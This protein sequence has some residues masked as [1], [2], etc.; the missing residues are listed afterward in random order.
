MRRNLFENAFRLLARIHDFSKTQQ[1]AAGRCER[2][3]DIPYQKDGSPDHLLD[4]YRPRHAAGPLPVMLYIHG[5]G[6]VMCDKNTHRGIGRIYADN[7][8]VVFNINYRLA[9]QHPYPAAL[10]DAGRA[11]AWVVENAA[12]YG[13]DPNRII[14]AGESAGGNLTLALA[15]AGCFRMHAP[16]ARAIWDV[17]VVPDIIMVMCGYLQ[18]SDPHR[19]FRVCPPINSFSRSLD[20]QIARDV[21]RAYLGRTYRRPDPNRI[22][23]DPLLALE[24]GD[25]PLR[26]FPMVYAMAGASDIIVDDTRRLEQAL[27]KRGIRHV[28]RYFPRQGHAFHLLGIS[29]QADRL[30]QDNLDFLKFFQCRKFIS[31][32]RPAA[33]TCGRSRDPG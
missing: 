12:R 25:M 8:H 33:Q 22:L 10:V 14:I 27:K 5:G 21:S 1:A 24:S 13:G 23:A 17:G 6:F 26:P 2:I 19:F 11:Y 9:P 16:E 31:A 28:A 32:A 29:R 18:V 7:G 3:P 15:A 4:I 30:W 20:V